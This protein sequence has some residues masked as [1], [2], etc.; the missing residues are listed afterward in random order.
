MKYLNHLA[1]V[2]LCFPIKLAIAFSILS[3]QLEKNGRLAFFIFTGDPANTDESEI[4]LEAEQFLE[5]LAQ[6]S[7]GL[8]FLQL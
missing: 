7:D 3:N 1:T 6:G 5:S 8:S 4:I 2:V